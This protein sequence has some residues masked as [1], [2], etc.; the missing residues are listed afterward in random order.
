MEV[1]LNADQEKWIRKQVANGRFPSIEEGVRV[2]FAFF[3]HELDEKP[4][5]AGD[6]TWAKPYID[7]GLAAIERGE[8]EQWEKGDILKKLHARHPGLVQN[9]DN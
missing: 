7:E 5:G 2:I 1:R 6:L 8:T 9:E 3:R 4:Y